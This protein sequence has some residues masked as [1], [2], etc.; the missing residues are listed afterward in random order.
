MTYTRLLALVCGLLTFSCTDHKTVGTTPQQGRQP[1]AA[2]EAGTRKPVARPDAPA[3]NDRPEGGCR[4]DFVYEVREPAVAGH[5]NVF[6]G[7]TDWDDSAEDCWA[8]LAE[9]YNNIAPDS[10]VTLQKAYFIA[11]PSKKAISKVSHW[12]QMTEQVKSRV[13]GIAVY[14]GKAETLSFKEAP[15]PRG[16]RK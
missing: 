11:E 3:A 2:T 12:S 16:P 1:H 13:I 6:V 10:G 5:A 9:Y 14:D 8:S 7:V 4:A 15:F